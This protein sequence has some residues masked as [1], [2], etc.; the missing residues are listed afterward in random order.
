MNRSGESYQRTND[1]P[2]HAG[3]MPHSVP[4]VLPIRGRPSKG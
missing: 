4:A 1:I 2:S 3:K